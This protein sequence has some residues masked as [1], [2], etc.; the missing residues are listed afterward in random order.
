MEATGNGVANAYREA[1]LDPAQRPGPE[2]P[3]L[4]AFIRRKV[5]MPDCTITLPV[6][7][8]AAASRAGRSHL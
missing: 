8:H 4:A 6:P 3:D 2:S 5:R 7:R 1:K